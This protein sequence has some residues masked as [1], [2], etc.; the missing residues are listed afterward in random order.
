VKDEG[1]RTSIV[2]RVYDSYIASIVV[3]ALLFWAGFSLGETWLSWDFRIDEHEEVHLEQYQS[4]GIHAERVSRRVV[5]SA[6]YSVTGLE[7]GYRREVEILK[8]MFIAVFVIST[9][10]T[11]LLQRPFP[12]GA[13][14]VPWGATVV[15]HNEMMSPAPD[16][17]KVARF[18]NQSTGTV[19]DA[20]AE[21]LLRTA[22]TVSVLALL[23]YAFYWIVY[24]EKRTA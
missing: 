21:P 16:I 4:E 20:I 11:L 7:A 15:L 19:V 23:V 18:T 5:R 8:E 14:G 2:A 22:I 9:G 6:R 24:R 3:G 1:V 12:M 17:E 10:A 13:I